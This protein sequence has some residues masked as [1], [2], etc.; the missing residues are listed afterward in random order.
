[1]EIWKVEIWVS[2]KGCGNL[3]EWEGWKFGWVEEGSLG[4][5]GKL[6]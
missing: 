3:G 4:E 1:M 6:W 2:G 5:W